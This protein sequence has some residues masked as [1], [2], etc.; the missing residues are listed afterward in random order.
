MSW[1]GF[2]RARHMFSVWEYSMIQPSWPHYFRNLLKITGVR[3]NER[4]CSVWKPCL[5]SINCTRLRQEKSADQILKNRNL[6]HS[7]FAAQTSSPTLYAWPF[8]FFLKIPLAAKSID[9]ILY[10]LRN[11][12]SL[13]IHF[14]LWFF[15]HVCVKSA[16]WAGAESRWN[17]TFFEF[18]PN[19]LL[20]SFSIIG[21]KIWFTNNR[22]STF[23]PRRTM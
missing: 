4:F 2:W 18:Y 15:I 12:C 17:A 13:G 6:H 5:F 8:K 11:Q 9:A 23:V 20:M 10:E 7:G 14:T 3:Y 16:A 19:I 21:L 1:V 22:A